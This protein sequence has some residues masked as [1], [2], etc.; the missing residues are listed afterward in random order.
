MSRGHTHHKNMI[1]IQVV[2]MK[3]KADTKTADFSY[4]KTSNTFP[5]SWTV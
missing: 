3:G 5:L 2:K 1:R 4:K